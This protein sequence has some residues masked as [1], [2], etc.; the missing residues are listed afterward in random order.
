M[1]PI[2]EDLYYESYIQQHSQYENPEIPA[3]QQQRDALE[4]TVTHALPKEM[5]ELFQQYQDIVTMLHFR[6]SGEEF[7]DGVSLGGRLLLEILLPR[8]PRP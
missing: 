8:S 6:E 3:L 2:L 7:A 4:Q 1:K 5:R